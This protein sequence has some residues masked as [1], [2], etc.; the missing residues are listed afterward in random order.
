MF[1]SPMEKHP[2]CTKCAK[3]S[4]VRS[5]GVYKTANGDVSRFY[6]GE[7]ELSFTTRSGTAL[8]GRRTAPKQIGRVIE[9]ILDG[10]TQRE[11]TAKIGISRN[12]L[13][14]WLKLLARECKD[15]KI[16]RRRYEDL[17]GLCEGALK[18]MEQ[19]TLTIRER[20]VDEFL[21]Q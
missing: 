18:G 21:E 20:P 13:A 9:L 4:R 19:E 6:C 15:S 12:T 16:N 7:C 8:A 1:E 5:K 10:A 2:P 14:D 17:L 11:A 3:S